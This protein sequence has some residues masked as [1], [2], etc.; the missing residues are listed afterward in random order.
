MPLQYWCLQPYHHYEIIGT[1][2]STRKYGQLKKKN[3]VSWKE[4]NILPMYIATTLTIVPSSMNGPSNRRGTRAKSRRKSTRRRFG[5]HGA[6]LGG[7]FSCNTMNCN[8]IFVSFLIFRLSA[9][10]RVSVC[11]R[12]RVIEH[13][14]I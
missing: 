2:R 6:R 5:D 10:R 4:S 8:P 3:M 1:Y 7:F 9:I 14:L 13:C 11:R 12:M